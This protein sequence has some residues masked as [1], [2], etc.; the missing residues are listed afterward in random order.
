MASVTYG[1]R[2]YGLRDMKVTNPAGTI[3]EDLDAAQTL[4]FT[5]QFTNADLRG[6]DMTV[7]S[8]TTVDGGTATVSAR[9]SSRG[10]GL[11]VRHNDRH[12]RVFA[13]RRGDDEGRRRRSDAVVQA[14]RLEPGAERR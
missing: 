3:Q 9:G 6:D 10:R 5:P 1:R 2:V 11:D 12:H 8:M 4:R 7:E 14:V 13:Q